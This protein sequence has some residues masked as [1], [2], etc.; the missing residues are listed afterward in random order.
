[1]KK[2]Y[3]DRNEQ[4]GVAAARIDQLRNQAIEAE[5]TREGYEGQMDQIKTQREYEALDKEIQDSGEREMELRRELQREE[6]KREEM[7]SALE[8]EELLIRKQEAEVADEQARIK[9]EIAVREAQLADLKEQ[10][11]QIIPGLDEELLY[12]FERIV[13]STDGLGI[14]PLQGNVCSGCFMTQPSHFVNRVRLGE[15]I[16]FCTHGR[17]VFYQ[18]EEP[19]WDDESE[20]P[21]EVFLEDDE[22][23]EEEEEEAEGEMEE[24]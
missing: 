3:L 8:K 2:S 9:S 24:E 7:Q 13:R 21:D 15:E 10:E 6:D 11:K 14:V 18:E 16:L 1:L 23:F 22:L 19:T 4:L 12:K 20:E 17:I 5:R